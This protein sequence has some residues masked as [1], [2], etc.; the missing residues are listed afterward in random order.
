M[1]TIATEAALSPIWEDYPSLI[2]SGD[3]LAGR[4][5]IGHDRTADT[6]VSSIGE[7]DGGLRR[8]F[9]LGGRA[10]KPSRTLG[11]LSWNGPRGPYNHSPCR[12]VRV[13][14]GVA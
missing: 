10:H 9:A 6:V 11:M 4:A 2:S 7:I 3:V 1:G 13:R 14:P 8:N 12:R 5:Y